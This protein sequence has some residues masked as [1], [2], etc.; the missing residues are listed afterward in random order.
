MGVKYFY[1]WLKR[2]CS[3]AIFSF[4][5]KKTIDVLALDL[6]GI[7]HPCAQRVFKYGMYSQHRGL[8]Q[9]SPVVPNKQKMTKLYAEIANKIHKLILT[10][11]P[12]KKVI[13]CIDG[14]AGFAK[15]NQQ[16]SRRF[17]SGKDRDSSTLLFDPN[18]ITPGTYFMSGLK[19]YLMFYFQS[20]IT[21]DARWSNLE[22]YFSPAD[23]EGEGEHK[24]L[25]Y[26]RKYID[27]KLSCCIV[28]MDADLVMLALTLQHE[29]VYIFREDEQRRDISIIDIT[30]LKQLLIK[31]M[32]WG[33]TFNEYHGIRDFVVLC[34]LVGND[35][36]PECPTVAILEDGIEKL[37]E[38]YRFFGRRHGHLTNIKSLNILP[39][40]K[41]LE[42]LSEFEETILN[43]RLKKK[44]YYFEDKLLL[45]YSKGSAVD[46]KSY[47]K[48]YYKKK[49]DGCKIESV[50]REY[51]RGLHWIFQY[52]VNGMPDWRWCYKHH[53][54]PFL[55][56]LSVYMKE[57]AKPIRFIIRPPVTQFQQLLM[58]LPPQ[59]ISLLPKGLHDV[60]SILKEFYP[61]TFEIDFSGKRNDWEAVVLLPFL[62]VAKLQKQFVTSYSKVHPRIREKN[63]RGVNFLMYYQSKLQ[64]RIRS[65]FGSF[66]NCNTRIRVVD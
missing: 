37:I 36:L 33:R 23:V 53:Y 11:K 51:T 60:M 64:K 57:N 39:F 20:M 56:D 25:L 44:G 45:E 54:A 55:S 15:M 58:V 32:R 30:L 52:Y 10:L 4:P 63:K 13:V 27:E 1:G 62:D 7:I 6:N 50:C 47:K 21:V 41:I 12:R 8:F 22:L 65:Q 2:K 40:S 26:L 43:T 9:A 28:G 16:R 66:D 46:L 61:E 5:C 17:R 3:E 24:I 49:M 29:H 19:Q 34:F 31:N 42:K 14:V 38:C 48:A 18:C 59:S 35:F